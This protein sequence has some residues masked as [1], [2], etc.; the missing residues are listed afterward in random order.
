MKIAPFEF[1]DTTALTSMISNNGVA[2]P[3][4]FHQHLH[5]ESYY[6]L[7]N[8]ASRSW[9]S[10]ADAIAGLDKIAEDLMKQAGKLK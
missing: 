3:I 4:E 5:K 10:K 7:V 6:T 2:L 1:V 9:N 8:T